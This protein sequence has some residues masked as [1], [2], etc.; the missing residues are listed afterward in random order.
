MIG[1]EMRDLPMPVPP[2][3]LHRDVWRAIEAQG[4]IPQRAPVST[5]MRQGKI[6]DFPGQ[7]GKG[8]PL[9]LRWLPPSVT[10]GRGL[11]LLLCWWLPSAS[12]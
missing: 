11:C 12:W 9:S 1:S 6:V 8:V 10:G 7:A 4:A 5:R 3:G 2:T